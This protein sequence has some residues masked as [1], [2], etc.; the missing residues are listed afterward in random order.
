MELGRGG[1][2]HT[3][4]HVS[5]PD[6]SRAH[7]TTSSTGRPRGSTPARACDT[8]T[9]TNAPAPSWRLARKAFSANTTLSTDLLSPGFAQRSV[10]SSPEGARLDP[11]SKKDDARHRPRRHRPR[12]HRPHQRRRARVRRRQSDRRAGC[13]EHALGCCLRTALVR[14]SYRSPVSKHALRQP[15]KSVTLATHMSGPP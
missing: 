13:R 9:W 14:Y 15:S 11:V 12:R 4:G 2:R 5:Q 1:T 8:A 3:D 6:A 7:V 10:D